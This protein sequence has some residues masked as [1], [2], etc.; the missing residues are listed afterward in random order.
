MKIFIVLIC[1]I[2]FASSVLG[3]DEAVKIEEFENPLCEEYLSR[4]DNAI[5]AAIHNPTAKIYVFVYEGKDINYKSKGHKIVLAF[6]QRGLAK[7]RLD[8][9]KKRLVLNEFP[10][11]NFVFINGGFRKNFTVEFWL[12]PAGVKPPEPTP[13]LRKMRYRKGKPEGLCTGCC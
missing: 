1:L 6:P 8:S 5:R 7:I 3:Q 4:F 2:A 12:V 11:E 10:T 13:T 9:I